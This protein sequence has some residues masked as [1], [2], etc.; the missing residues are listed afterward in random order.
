MQIIW[1]ILG[2]IAFLLGLASFFAM[3]ASIVHFKVLGAMI[4]FFATTLFWGGPIFLH[5]HRQEQERERLFR[6]ASFKRLQ[7]ELES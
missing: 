5:A 7:Q 2:A 6:A 4:F 1:K 3:L